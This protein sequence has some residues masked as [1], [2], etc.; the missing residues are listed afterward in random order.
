MGFGLEDNRRLPTFPD[1]F[2]IRPVIDYDVRKNCVKPYPGH[3]KGCPNFNDPKHAHRC[4]PKAPRF[5]DFFN[6]RAPLFAV[7]NH[8][9]LAGFVQRMRIAHPDWSDAQLYNVLRWQGSARKQLQERIDYVL[10][11][12][13]FQGAVATWCPEGM[14]MDVDATMRKAGLE[15]EWPARIIARQVAI[16]GYPL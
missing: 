13:L 5:E 10:S 15:L 16:I 1:F 2:R 11:F 9:D 14:G 8:Y 3:K 7:V 12:D 4:P 6:V